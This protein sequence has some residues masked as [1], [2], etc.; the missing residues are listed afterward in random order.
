M[1][2]DEVST[3]FQTLQ[4]LCSVYRV[5]SGAQLFL[6]A[7]QEVDQQAIEEALGIELGKEDEDE[8]EEQEGL[9]RALMPRHDLLD[10]TCTLN[11]HAVYPSK[12]LTSMWL[13]CRRAV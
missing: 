8:D 6:F 3:L 1:D 13:C 5:E 11:R 10:S 4:L 9:H 7:L 12:V 2:S